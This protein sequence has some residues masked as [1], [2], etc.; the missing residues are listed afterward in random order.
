MK[1]EGDIVPGDAARLLTKLLD[2]YMIYGPA[3]DTVYLMSTGGDVDEAMK[4]GTMIRRLRLKTVAPVWDTDH[5]PRSSVLADNWKNVI[6]ASACFLVYAGGIDRFGNY[7]VLHRPYI[8]AEL[9]GKLSGVGYETALKQEMLKV[10]AYL[11]NME[12]DA[13]WIEKMMSAN[14][15]NSYVVTWREANNKARHLMGPVPSIAEILRAKCAGDSM[16][17]ERQIESA[18]GEGASPVGG[19]QA[20]RARSSAQAEDF[21]SCKK[22]MLDDIRKAAFEREIEETLMPQCVNLSRQD[23]F[24]LAKLN[25][26]SNENDAPLTIEE[27]SLKSKLMSKNLIFLECRN[28]AMGAIRDSAFKREA[29]DIRRMGGQPRSANGDSR[30]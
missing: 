2:F 15:Q 11:Q 7:L 1:V 20:L 24:V 26:K 18:D 22:N 17:Q 6:C 27:E 29:D 8:L 13:S 5:P 9:S 21:L 23:R 25:D 12:V 19:D 4:L 28:K 30:E 3:I 14:L 16:D 10:A